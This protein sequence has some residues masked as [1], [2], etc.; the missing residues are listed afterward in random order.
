M[1]Q[2]K[3]DKDSNPV[4]LGV[5]EIKVLFDSIS[6]LVNS[7]VKPVIVYSGN[8]VKVV[9]D[10]VPFELKVYDGLEKKNFDSYNGAFDY[11]FSEEVKEEKPK[12]KQEKEIEKFRRRLE[13]QEETIKELMEKE[14]KEREKGELIYQN[15]EIVANVLSELNKALEKYDWKEIE[16]RLKGHKLVK[17]VNSK[18]KTIDIEV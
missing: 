13:G 7:K 9:K 17:A 18:E 6:K 4:E 12:T 1:S 8:E 3:V 16:N 10:I 15:Y 5:G 11:Y 2:S 14:V